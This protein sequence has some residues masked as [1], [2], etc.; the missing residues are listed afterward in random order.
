MGPK[1]LSKLK[2]KSKAGKVKSN[3][4]GGKAP[5][6]DKKGGGKGDKSKLKKGS[7]ISAVGSAIKKEK[8]NKKA[9]ADKSKVG[10]KPSRTDA[11]KGKG[12][13][14]GKE[15]SKKKSTKIDEVAGSEVATPPPSE[16][17][18]SKIPPASPEVTAKNLEVLKSILDL[19]EKLKP[20]QVNI[21]IKEDLDRVQALVKNISY[22][23][24]GQLARMTSIQYTETQL[25]VFK[26]V[27]PT[28]SFDTEDKLAVTLTKEKD[29]QPVV[30]SKTEAP[31]A[32]SASL[33][34]V[35]L[36]FAF[37]E[38]KLIVTKE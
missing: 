17:P 13:G 11:G 4:K 29:G 22:R 26:I 35:K 32:G 19:I 30:G 33:P 15:P 18:A 3:A 21:P 24:S 7:K 23:N 10:K 36:G 34:E 27:S 1:K 28:M 6:A 9:K 38:P 37:T 16:V 5:K 8:D 2:A 12:K 25:S 14:K 31:T 20:D